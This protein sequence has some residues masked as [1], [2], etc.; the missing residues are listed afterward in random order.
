MLRDLVLVGGGHAHVGVLRRF[1][2]Q[3]EPGVR[4]TLISRA[5]ASPYSGMLPGYIAGHY[6]WDEVHIDLDRLC[7][8]AQATLIRGEVVG[9]DRAAR[10]VLLAGRPPIAYDLLS[11]NLGST[12]KNDAVPG[13]AEHAVGVKPIDGFNNRWLS[14]YQ[15]LSTLPHRA[16]IAV[17]GAGAAG[18][19]LA[20]ALHERLGARLRELGRPAD[21]PLI[22][23]YGA[24]PRLLPTHADAVRRRVRPL[25][26]ARGI[27]LRLGDPVT[28][29]DA[30]ALVW[31]GERFSHDEIIWVTQ[32]GGAPWLRDTG[33]ALDREG[34]IEVESSLRSRSDAAVFAAGDI[35]SYPGRALEKA[36]VFA[37]RMGRPLADNLRRALRGE[38]LRPYRPQRHWLA[39][40]ATGGRHAIASRGPFGFAGHW[41]WHWKDWI[42]RRFMRRFSALPMPRE[43]MPRSLAT[44]GHQ[45]ALDPAEATQ[46]LSVLAMRCGGCGAKV[47]ADILSRVLAR[48]DPAHHPDVLIGLDAPD[49]AAV[50]ALPAGQA[51]VQSVDFFRS[52]IEDPWLFGR[53]AATHALSDL[54]AMG[55]SPQSAAALV[56]V[57]P[58]LDAKVEELLV[59]L[60]SGA[61]QVLREAGCALVGGHTAEGQELAMGFAVNGTT[62]ASLTALMRKSGLMP[63]DA[64]VLTKPLGTGTLLVAREMLAARGGWIDEALASML[65]SNQAAAQCLR[66]HGVRACTD[67]TGFGLLG[68]LHEMVR[69]S[70]VAARLSLGAIPA[71][72]GALSTLASGHRSSL[73]AGNLRIAPLVGGFER[74]AEDPRVQL[75]FDPQTSGGLLAGVP[76]DRARECVEALHAL[77]CVA[78]TVVGEV[79]APGE[80]EPLLALV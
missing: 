30:G 18:V 72:A 67:V 36:G 47:G 14:L 71:L 64:L 73:H 28:R 50:I 26:A 8:F 31:R 49:D 57:P 56:T 78:A 54:F 32:A 3:P 4:L 70:G 75:L 48:L 2:M 11:L 25:L 12:P 59:Q 27:E 22:A 66:A 29:V 34:F 9:I 24:D 21:T 76:A 19:E 10:R 80:G 40:L 7:R 77:G 51:L 79:V 43:S 58:A 23:L 15:R 53:I 68:H 20:F 55:A 37:V 16:S 69:A 33:L 35:V 5:S 74:L 61:L 63:G 45:L 13:A 39:L 38:P 65:Q 60:M 17:V 44:E 41:V 42:D 6:A 46:A 52:F 1:A 62:P